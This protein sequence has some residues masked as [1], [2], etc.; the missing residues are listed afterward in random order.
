M[1]DD[2]AIRPATDAA[3]AA[4]L[5]GWTKS[6]NFPV[7]N[8]NFPSSVSASVA[9]VFVA[10]LNPAN[11]N[12]DYSIV[13]GGAVRYGL[14]T[15]RWMAMAGAC[16]G[17]NCFAKFPDQRHHRNSARI[18]SGGGMRSCPRL[19]AM[20]PRSSTRLS[21]GAQTDRAYGVALDAARE[22]YF[23]GTTV[24]STFPDNSDE[25]RSCF[26][27]HRRVHRQAGRS[28]G[29]DHRGSQ[30]QRRGFPPG[31]SAE[32][33]LQSSTNLITNAG[34]RRHAGAFHER[35]AFGDIATHHR[36]SSSAC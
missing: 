25:F 15:S 10:K 24:Y 2:E 4:H 19:T 5:T 26:Q 21:G 16:G 23:V 32:F 9:D 8:T 36:P 14:G 28:T 6:G 33:G 29:A 3:G 20:A 22:L 31:Y 18:N 11:T 13:F 30:D 17:R 27:R 35:P 34:E 1:N 12:L 7:T